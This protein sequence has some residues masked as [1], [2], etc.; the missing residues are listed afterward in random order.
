LQELISN[1]IQNQCLYLMLFSVDELKKQCCVSHS[2]NHNK[3][4]AVTFDMKQSVSFQI[5]P[6]FLTKFKQ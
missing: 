2:L 6:F 4:C 5:L 3:I 1:S